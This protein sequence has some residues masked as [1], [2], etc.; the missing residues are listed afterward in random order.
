MKKRNRVINFL[1]FVLLQLVIVFPSLAANYTASDIALTPGGNESKLNLAW[2]TSD[3]GT[4]ECAVQVA[5]KSTGFK[6]SETFTG[7]KEGAD[8]NNDGTVDYYYCS[9]SVSD[10]KNQVNYIYRLGD[11]NGKWSDTYNYSTENKNKYSFIFLSDAQIGASR[12]VTDD[13]AK[14]LNTINVINNEFPEAAFILSAGDQIENPGN[15]SQWTGFFSPEALKSIPLAPTPA[16]HDELGNGTGG[17]PSSYAFDYH[18]NLPNE[19]EHFIVEACT[20]NPPPPGGSCS[21]TVTSEL[22]AG[23][24]WFTYGKALFMVLNMDS[25]NYAAHEA[26]MQNAINENPDAKWRIAM[27]HYTIYTASDRNPD[28]MMR[29]EL[30][31]IMDDL[32]IDLVFMGHDHLYCRTKQMYQGN[33]VDSIQTNQKG[34]IINPDGTLYIDGGSSSGSKYYA[35]SPNY[36]KDASTG[37]WSWKEGT[38]DFLAAIPFDSFMSEVFVPSRENPPGSGNFTVAYYAKQM[39]VPTFS[40]ITIEGNTLSITTYS[41]PDGNGDVLPIDDTYTIFKN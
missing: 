25:H 35:T 19:T 27:W 32:N 7:I 11:N 26:F 12:K 10:L 15:E 18:F 2:V 38:A 21:N 8:T 23:D 3:S 36:V 40:N 28:A 14:W 16:A 31:N 41:A 39:T 5:K 33:P 4:E 13:T 30:Y 6:N 22:A 37:S 29:T 9:V 17:A 1:F 34:W 24:Y 20:D